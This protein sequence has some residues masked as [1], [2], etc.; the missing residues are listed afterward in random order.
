MAAARKVDPRK[1]P[2]MPL[3]AEEQFAENARIDD[4]AEEIIEDAIIE[5]GFKVSAAEIRQDIIEL[6][7]FAREWAAR[8]K[9][10]GTA[11]IWGRHVPGDPPEKITGPRPEPPPKSI[12]QREREHP[13]AAPQGWSGPPLHKPDPP[14]WAKPAPSIN[15]ATIGAATMPPE[16]GRFSVSRRNGTYQEISR[17]QARAGT[18]SFNETGIKRW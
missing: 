11:Q 14:V 12:A 4:E 17:Q 18:V 9:R 5:R 6:R 2:P 15:A 7:A 13:R 10:A 1:L 16:E 8:P 3:D